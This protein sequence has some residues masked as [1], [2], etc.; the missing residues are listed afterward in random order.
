VSDDLPLDEE[1]LILGALLNHV[2]DKGVVLTGDVT[3]SV[4]DVDLVRLSLAVMLSSVE[5]QLRALP[6]R[7]PASDAALSVL[8]DEPGR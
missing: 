1:R 7:T 6:V 5:A 3:I 4:A 2:L 8:P